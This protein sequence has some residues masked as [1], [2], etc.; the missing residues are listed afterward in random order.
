MTWDVEIRWPDERVTTV[1]R[2]RAAKA[3]DRSVLAQ[4]ESGAAVECQADISPGRYWGP[5]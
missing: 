1:S 5:A 3:R 4:T 2:S